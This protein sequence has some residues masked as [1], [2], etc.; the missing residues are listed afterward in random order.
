[1]PE[2]RSGPGG[3][4]LE[5]T[6]EHVGFSIEGLR[7]CSLLAKGGF[8]EVWE[9]EQV[10]LGRKVAVK[11]LRSEHLGE[12]QMVQLFEQESRVLARLNHFNV[13]QV[14]DRGA[15]HQGPYFVMEYVEGEKTLA[16]QKATFA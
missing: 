10:S 5:P 14:I 11:I 4:L 1:M 6:A 13:V 9:A 12:E 16:A 8:A 3:A 2:L 15:T 7:L